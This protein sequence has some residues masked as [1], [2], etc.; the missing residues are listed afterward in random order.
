MM[1]HGICLLLDFQDVRSVFWEVGSCLSCCVQSI[2]PFCFV[3]CWNGICIVKRFLVLHLMVTVVSA[4]CENR[5]SEQ[6]QTVKL[7]VTGIYL[8]RTW[9]GR[10]KRI[11][12]AEALILLT[13]PDTTHWNSFSDGHDTPSLMPGGNKSLWSLRASYKSDGAAKTWISSTYTEWLEERIT[14]SLQEY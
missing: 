3:K 2:F 12:L 13:G 1:L 8:G 10:G 5:S 7:N 9:L 6:Q 14:W 11:F 4:A